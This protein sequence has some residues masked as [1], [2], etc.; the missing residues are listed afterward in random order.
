MFFFIQNKPQFTPQHAELLRNSPVDAQGPG[1]IL[2]DFE[3]L[4]AFF[5]AGRMPLTKG[6]QLTLKA[7]PNLNA[8]L[9]RPLA[10]GLSRPLQKAFPH[11]EGLYLLLRASGLTRVEIQGKSPVLVVDERALEAWQALNPTERYCTLLEVWL[12]GAQ[13]QIIGRT[14]WGLISFGSTFDFWV[15][16]VSRIP[17]TG[18]TLKA[19]P[20]LEASLYLFETYNLALLELF[21]LLEIEH[22]PPV[23]GA[24]WQIG[25][26]HRTA[27]GDALC[28]LLYTNFFA[29]LANVIARAVEPA[30]TPGQLLP[31]LQP[32]L[33]AWQQTLALPTPEFRDGI[34]IFRV[35]LGGTVWRRIAIPAKAD[36]DDL[37]NAILDAFE[38]SDRMHLYLFSYRDRRGLEVH[39]YH[40]EV[41]DADVWA[42]E[43]T[44]G[45]LPLPVGDAMLFWFDFGDNWEFNVRLESIEPQSTPPVVDTVVLEA[46]GEAPEQYPIWEDDWDGDWEEADA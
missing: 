13:P 3:M 44:I 29:E 5:S 27:W 2:R 30:P 32:Y 15:S 34:Y 1:T 18:T 10:L 6:R 31:V 41:E 24:G 39:A 35:D 33:L 21:G 23:P 4:L 12:L 19:D 22:L 17:D 9:S 42:V 26:L 11:L 20:G 14:R 28:A 8:Q 36:L 25:L 40:R 46:H 16:L 37:A 7:L 43:V 38:F 45:D